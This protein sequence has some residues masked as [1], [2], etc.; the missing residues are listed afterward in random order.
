[1]LAHVRLVENRQAASA[2]VAT[3]VVLVKRDTVDLGMASRLVAQHV[4]GIHDS[5]TWVCLHDSRKKLCSSLV[6]LLRDGT[7][8]ATI[9][10]CHTKQIKAVGSAVI[11]FF[12]K[13]RDIVEHDYAFTCRIKQGNRDRWFGF[14]LAGETAVQPG[15]VLSGP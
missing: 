8:V 10:L 12:G 1:M 11:Q 4:I 7:T 3:V 14:E 5:R 9:V 15:P 13:D 2:Q 6:V